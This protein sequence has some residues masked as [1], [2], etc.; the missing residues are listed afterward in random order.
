MTIRCLIKFVAEP[1]QPVWAALQA[2]EF[3]TIAS[4]LVAG[5]V[6]AGWRGCKWRDAA[7]PG[8]SH[9]ALL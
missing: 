3:L 2:G 7:R 9:A 4:A 6:P 5:T 8:D 1:V